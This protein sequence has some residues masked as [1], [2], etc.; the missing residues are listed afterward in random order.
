MS[1][2]I[3]VEADS[4][5][6]GREGHVNGWIGTAFTGSVESSGVSLPATIVV[7]P[8]VT[9]ENFFKTKDEVYPTPKEGS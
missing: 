3:T 2:K 6:E 5:L 9:P 7:M 1:L 8:G 4:Y